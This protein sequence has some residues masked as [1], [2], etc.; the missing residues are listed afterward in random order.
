MDF[1]LPVTITHLR[2]YDMDFPEQCR[3]F[4]PEQ[5]ADALGTLYA[6][7]DHPNL[8][9][10]AKIKDDAGHEATINQHFAFGEQR[11]FAAF[12]GI[13][14]DS[15]SNRALPLGILGFDEENPSQV[16]LVNL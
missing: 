5:F 3:Q 15:E 11:E 7:V 2:V 8:C 10:E 6:S 13:W 14:L 12:T 1:K 4:K 16:F 9:L